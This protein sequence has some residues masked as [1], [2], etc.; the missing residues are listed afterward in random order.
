[1]P[2]QLQ[3][4]ICNRRSSALRSLI[5]EIRSANKFLNFDVQDQHYAYF[6]FEIKNPKLQTKTTNIINLEGQIMPRRGRR[7]RCLLQIQFRSLHHFQP[8]HKKTI[9][10]R[11]KTPPSK[12]ITGQFLEPFEYFI[13]WR[14]CL[15]SRN[16]TPS[17]QNFW[18]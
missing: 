15:P 14:G 6:E 12:I 3:K 4:H 1:M 13:V 2:K 5:P 18:Q 7:R 16:T 17:S 8:F 10:T 9:S 11:L